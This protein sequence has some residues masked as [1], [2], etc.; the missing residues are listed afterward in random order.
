MASCVRCGRE[1]P[2][3][4]FGDLKDV[5]PDCARA[6]TAESSVPQ[7]AVKARLVTPGRPVTTAVVAICV[8]VFALMVLR[9]I[10]PTKPT[11]DQLLK[12]GADWGPLTFKGQWWRTLTSAFLH[13]GIVHLAL[14][15][16]CLWSLGGLAEAIFRRTNFLI[17]YVL[18]A[19]GGA[20][21]SL[22]WHPQVVG[23]GA[24]GAVFG[25]AGALIAAFYFGHLP[26]PRAMLKNDLTSL[27]VF[28]AYN[29]AYGAIHPHIDNAAHLGGLATGLILGALL[30]RRLD[31]EQQGFRRAAFVGITLVL[32]LGAWAVQRA[33]GYVVHVQA[34][35]DALDSKRYDAAVREFSAVT[36][37]K[38]KLA[39]GYFLLGEALTRAKRYA[40]AERAYLHAIGLDPTS[41]T[42]YEKLGLVYLATNRFKPAQTVLTKA[43]DLDPSLKEAQ[44]YQAM[45]LEG[46]GRDDEAIAAYQK[47]VTLTPTYAF[48]FFRL[49]LLQL[50]H[51]RPEP[52]LAAFKEAVRLQPSTP[53]YQLGLAAAYRANGM[54]D[55]A[56]T[57]LKK[58][59]E[60]KK[61]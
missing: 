46:L 18:C 54:T 1:L 61:N 25:V 50:N 59:E 30:G 58:A 43:L 10:S 2:R 53:E 20:V 26:I 29:L 9:G 15:M 41:G 37:E 3:F 12:W 48:G 17:I 6:A 52:A 32:V 13:I 45:A 42:A 23:A 39:A 35:V 34:G 47:A 8:A 16:W 22:A 49:G 27:L 21:A 55:E 44:G 24:S 5:C 7:P 33:N 56:Q 57:A 28:A 4:S 19:L 40:E 31:A 38:P 51:E 36:A 60:L 11:V 14:N